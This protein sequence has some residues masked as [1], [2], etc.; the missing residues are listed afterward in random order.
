VNL[1][2]GYVLLPREVRSRCCGCSPSLFDSDLDAL[3]DVLDQHRAAALEPLNAIGSSESDGENLLGTLEQTAK[4]CSPRLL[5]AISESG[6]RDL[7]PRPLR[8]ELCV[9]GVWRC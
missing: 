3:A 7:N 8:P 1:P 4:P 5:A 6:W 2:D 9:L